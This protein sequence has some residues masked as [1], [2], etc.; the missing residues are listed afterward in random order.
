M[1]VWHTVARENESRGG[2]SGGGVLLSRS[3]F[4]EWYELC[5]I[6]KGQNDFRYLQ[7]FVVWRTFLFLEHSVRI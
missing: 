3:G 7:L 6:P 4:G 2:E 1:T 5:T